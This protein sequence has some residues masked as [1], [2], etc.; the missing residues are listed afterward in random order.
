MKLLNGPGKL[1]ELVTYR[2]MNFQNRY[3]QQNV[4]YTDLNE[5]QK[6]QAFVHVL[7]LNQSTS[8]FGGE[9]GAVGIKSWAANT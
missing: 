4:L 7:D 6:L 8:I 3:L 5:R 9:E 1:S 2:Q